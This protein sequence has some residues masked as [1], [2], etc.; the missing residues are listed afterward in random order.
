MNTQ[1]ALPKFFFEIHFKNWHSHTVT[2]EEKPNRQSL[3]SEPTILDL[4]DITVDTW[5][6]AYVVAIDPMKENQTADTAL[7]YAKSLGGALRVVAIE[8][9]NSYEVNFGHK[10]PVSKIVTWVKSFQDN[11]EQWEKDAPSSKYPILYRQ[12]GGI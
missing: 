10:M 5:T 8:R 4:D 9:V 1:L 6:I 7:A 11:W 2:L 3:M 12:N